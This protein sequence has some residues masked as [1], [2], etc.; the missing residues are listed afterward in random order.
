MDDIGNFSHG[1]H[2][3]KTTIF[4][5]EPSTKLRSPIIAGLAGTLTLAAF[6]PAYAATDAEALQICKTEVEA[7]YGEKAKTKLKRIRS[8]GG[9][10]KVSM[11]VRGVSENSFKIECNVDDNLQVTGFVDHRADV[12]AL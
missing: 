9:E 7:R 8:R 3:Y 2:D 4:F 1:V 11:F 12:A 6:V 5:S 10:T